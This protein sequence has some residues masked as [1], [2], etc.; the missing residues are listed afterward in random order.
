MI[1]KLIGLFLIFIIIYFSVKALV[2]LPFFTNMIVGSSKS[3]FQTGTDYVNQMNKIYPYSQNQQVIYNQDN[4]RNKILDKITLE[5]SYGRL[6]L[7]VENARPNILL[8]IWLTNNPQITDKTEYINFGQLYKDESIRDYVVDM[9]GG[10]ISF[11]IF[12]YIL[13]VDQNNNIYA[14]INLK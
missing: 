11:D 5:K 7:S 14:Q 2:F 1:K 8:N 12:K 10:D 13:I 3:P 4:N 9:K 6:T